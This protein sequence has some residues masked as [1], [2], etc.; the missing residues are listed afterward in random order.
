[1]P[2]GETKV[3]DAGLT[4]LARLQRLTYLGLR[5]DAITDAGLAELKNLTDLTGLHLGQTDVT[6]QG[7]ARLEPL[8]LGSERSGC[9]TQRSAMPPSRPWGGSKSLESLHVYRT[10]MTIAG[11]AA[12]KRTLPACKISTARSRSRNDDQDG[13]SHTRSMKENSWRDHASSNHQFRHRH[14]CPIGETETIIGL[15]R[16]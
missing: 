16:G 5:G 9:T 6:D 11:I 2:L 4:H 12:P 15:L 8:R 13:L 10:N 1:M 3:T 14:D 7:M